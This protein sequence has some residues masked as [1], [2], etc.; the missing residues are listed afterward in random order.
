MAL[1]DVQHRAFG[2]VFSCY[3]TIVIAR[4][5]ELYRAFGREFRHFRRVLS[6]FWMD[7]IA[8]SDVFVIERNI[9]VR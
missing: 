7:T 3:R 4:S 2:R 5:D 8:L 9:P 6:R 1:S